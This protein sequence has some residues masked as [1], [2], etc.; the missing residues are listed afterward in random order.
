M[1]AI[2]TLGSTVL[3]RRF[4]GESLEHAIEL[5]E[6]LKPNRECDLTDSK[7]DIFQ[8]LPRFLKAG[9][10]DVIDEIY[11]GHLLEFFAEVR[12]RDVNRSRHFG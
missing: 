12:G 10:S 5:R 6:R 9:P 7:I 8:K 1:P 2:H 4:P 11:S 3:R